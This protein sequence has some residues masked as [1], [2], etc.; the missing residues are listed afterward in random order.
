MIIAKIGITIIAVTLICAMWY[1]IGN[2][3]G[4]VILNRKDGMFDSGDIPKAAF[5]TLLAL[6]ATLTDIYLI[7]L[8]YIG[9]K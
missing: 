4:T 7:S 2:V 3:I 8:L 1:V 5:V 6:G 9:G